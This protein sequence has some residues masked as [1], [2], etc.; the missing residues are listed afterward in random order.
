MSASPKAVRSGGPPGKAPVSQPSAPPIHG[1]AAFDEGLEGEWL[2]A[3]REQE[4]LALLLI[5]VDH[6]PGYARKAGAAATEDSLQQIAAVLMQAV[7]RPTDLVVRY[8]EAQFAIV[9][10]THEA[11]A[12]VV[13]ARARH[14]VNGLALPHR[15]G[16]GGIVTVSIGVAALTPAPEQPAHGLVTLA[17]EALAQARRIGH[18]CIVSQDWIA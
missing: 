18:D 16:E 10:P 17:E 14:A 4:S 1:R 15:A 12:R 6:F 2:R 13:A 5:E 8:G 3:G 11:G 9:L 7:F